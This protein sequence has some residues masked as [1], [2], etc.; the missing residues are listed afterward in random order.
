M[1]FGD[2]K[3]K[4]SYKNNVNRKSKREEDVKAWLVK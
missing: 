4:K 1:D 3:E 2:E